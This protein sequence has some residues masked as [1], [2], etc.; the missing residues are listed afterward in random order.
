MFKAIRDAFGRG[1]RTKQLAP[2]R[3]RLSAQEWPAVIY[4]IGDVH[5][6]LAEA[7]QLE[8]TILEDGLD[9]AGEKW[10]VY[11]G[12]YID[13]GP[14]SAGVLDFLLTRLPQGWRRIC[15]AGNHEV[16]ALEFMANPKPGSGWLEFGGVETLSSYGIQLA[17]LMK[18]SAAE[19]QAIIHSHVPEEHLVFL[20]E[21][22]SILCLPQWIFVHAG[23]RRG[24]AIADQDENDLFWIRDEFFN[25]P[26]DQGDTVV[27]G[28]TPAAAPVRAEG[29][30]C[31]DTGCFATG[32]LTAVRLTQGG[33]EGF[34]NTTSR[35]ADDGAPAAR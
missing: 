30:I 27:H 32:T 5:G 21:M 17:A 33:V 2:A 14:D 11:L 24:V 10:I 7:R 16:M 35:R 18:K 26:V 28:H 13:R 4:A 20:R 3:R 6:C 29:R 8:Q 9:I 25:S 19:R 34:L 15:L 31:V 12:D 1:A 22:P 23:I